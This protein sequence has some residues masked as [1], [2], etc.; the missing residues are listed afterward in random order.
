MRHVISPRVSIGVSRATVGVIKTFAF[1]FCMLFVWGLHWAI[2][3]FAWGLCRVC[4]GLPFRVQS[5][6]RCTKYESEGTMS[7]C[8]VSY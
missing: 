6:G 4:M 7:H 2:S 5:V 3:R 1:R 8:H